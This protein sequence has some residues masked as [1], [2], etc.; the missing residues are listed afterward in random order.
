M[1]PKLFDVFVTVLVFSVTGMGFS[2]NGMV[3]SV[4]GMVFSVTGTSFSEIV[5]SA[6][7]LMSS[8][9]QSWKSC[10]EIWL[11]TFLFTYS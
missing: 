3:F 8:S 5:V 4:T 11:Q 2:F 9:P 1:T 7:L 6:V 10:T